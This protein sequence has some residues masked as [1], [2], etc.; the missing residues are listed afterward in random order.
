[1]DIKSASKAHNSEN[2]LDG[3]IVQTQYSEPSAVGRP[4]VTVTRNVQPAAAPPLQP[5]T[6]PPAKEGTGSLSAGYTIP[7]VSNRYSGRG[8]G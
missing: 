1:M 8:E 2:S 6:V 4:N 3:V 5:P 7:R